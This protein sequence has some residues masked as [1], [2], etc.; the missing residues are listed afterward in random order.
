MTRKTHT[1][2]FNKQDNGGEHLILH[3]IWTDANE[4]KKGTT[5]E[6]YATQELILNSYCNSVNLNLGFMFTP[7]SLRELANQIELMQQFTLG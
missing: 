3:T 6:Y 4:G 2:T 1:F 7:E 5:P